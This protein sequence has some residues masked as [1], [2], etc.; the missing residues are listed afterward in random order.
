MKYDKATFKKGAAIASPD[1]FAAADQAMGLAPT[2]TPTPAA[3][4]KPAPLL[5]VSTAR[6]EARSTG[7][8]PPAGVR[9]SFYMPVG[10]T[11]V[12]RRLARRVEDTGRFRPS[13][14]EV[15]RAGLQL[16]DT[17]SHQKLVAIVSKVSVRRTKYSA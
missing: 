14:G 7:P 3:A 11:D 10:E 17:L 2:S 9:T 13:E 6:T 15:I 12:L 8:K 1:R 5:R 4:T 16:L